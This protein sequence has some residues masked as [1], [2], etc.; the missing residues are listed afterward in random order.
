MGRQSV[1][2]LERLGGGGEEVVVVRI[3]SILVCAAFL[4]SG[5]GAGGARRGAAGDAA[6]GRAGDAGFGDS[7]DP[8]VSIEEFETAEERSGGSRSREESKRM[9]ARARFTLHGIPGDEGERGEERI[10][11][12]A[13][14]LRIVL[15]RKTGEDVSWVSW[16]AAAAPV[17]GA[18]SLHAGSFSPDFAER[19][20]AGASAPSVFSSAFPANERR[21]IA[22]NT[23]GYG[24]ALIGGAVEARRGPVGAIIFA[25][26]ERIIRGG[27]LVMGGATIAGGRVEARG[28]RS[29]AGI[30]L[31]TGPGDGR[32]L[33]AG[34]DARVERGPLRAAFEAARGRA[35]G[36]AACAAISARRGGT[37]FGALLHSIPSGG[38]PFGAAGGGNLSS[39][40]S[41][42]GASVMAE[43]RIARRGAF[44][45]AIERTVRAGDT[46]R[47]ERA[48]A[49]AELEKKWKI[50]R[51][52][53]SGA[54]AG[55][56]E[57]P[58][59]PQPGCE[60]PSSEENRSCG[61]LVDLYP[62]ALFSMRLALKWVGESGGGSGILI[63][64]MIRARSRGGGVAATVSYAGYRVHG[65]A[66]ACYYYEPS[67]EGVYP[68]KYASGGHE[69]VACLIS[70]KYSKIQ[71]SYKVVCKMGAAPDGTVQALSVF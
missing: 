71:I 34:A 22:S 46:E 51:L 58:L 61:L 35:G 32:R 63:A 42:G 3:A 24:R 30:S 40:A 59:L 31:M 43:R 50:L 16:F 12:D 36:I 62:A 2:G 17:R 56:E 20:V 70:I 49:R 52:K 65:R 54:A 11:I 1:A 41:Y 23:S 57:T 18:L 48:I 19:L 8:A 9:S 25:G 44:R 55:S 26:R 7:V 45:A 39:I 6:A 33:L 27:R 13:E 10:S 68:W 38:C 47:R 66:P 14:R 67:L 69:T 21:W 64:P 5:C 28:G 53:L 29:L 4:A 37:R 15:R 60:P